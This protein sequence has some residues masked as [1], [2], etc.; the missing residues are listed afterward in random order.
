MTGSV[1]AIHR[2]RQPLKEG[3]SSSETGGV[4]HRDLRVVLEWLGFVEPDR[5][6]REPIAL[7]RWAPWV[8][9]LFIVTAAALGAFVITALLGALR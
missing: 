2:K 7:P 6:R 1:T 4:P 3:R 9:T 5:S 8:V